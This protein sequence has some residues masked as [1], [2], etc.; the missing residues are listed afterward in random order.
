MLMRQ[1][2]T[3]SK[4]DAQSTAHTALE[5]VHAF[6]SGYR[7]YA[8]SCRSILARLSHIFGAIFI[9]VHWY[10]LVQH[11]TANCSPQ[12]ASKAHSALLHLL[13]KLSNEP[14]IRQVRQ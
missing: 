8:Q 6:V 10:N 14:N 3:Y 5:P 11:I 1:S 9:E 2:G 12:A 7:S 13:V 4:L